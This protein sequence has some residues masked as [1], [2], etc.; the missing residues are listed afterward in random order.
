MPRERRRHIIL[1]A[2]EREFA[3][4]GYERASMEEIARRSQVTKALLYQHFET[5]R[6]L[7]TACAL[8]AGERWLARARERLA[9]I[10]PG[11]D[12]LRA[13]ATIYFDAVVSTDPAWRLT[14]GGV[15]PGAAA[16]ISRGRYAELLSS[17]LLAS[18][19]AAGTQAEARDIQLLSHALA[20]AAE[21]VGRWWRANAETSQEEIVSRFNALA[22]G[23]I[24]PVFRELEGRAGRRRR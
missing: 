10:P 16:D 13:F 1:A 21:Q 24:V 11:P 5:K 14:F 15:G 17:V 3:R 19:E 2:G 22:A 20:G 18:L 12:Q 6:D 9:E 7:Y 23:A 8:T 4:R